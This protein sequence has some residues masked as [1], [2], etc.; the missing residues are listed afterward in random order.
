[1][2][3]LGNLL[4]IMLRYFEPIDQKTA[5]PTVIMSTVNTICYSDFILAIPTLITRKQP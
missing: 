5:H 2:T 4:M 3:L 1:M